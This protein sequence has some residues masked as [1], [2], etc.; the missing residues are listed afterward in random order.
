MAALVHLLEPELLV[1]SP[2]VAAAAVTVLVV[3]L[4][5]LVA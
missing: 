1:L 5:A 4:V 3:A 2:V